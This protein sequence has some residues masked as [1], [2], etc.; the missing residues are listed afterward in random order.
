MLKIIILF[1]NGVYDIMP[2]D[3]SNFGAQQSDPD[4]IMA[5]VIR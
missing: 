1:A 5:Y 4:Y 2:F 3:L